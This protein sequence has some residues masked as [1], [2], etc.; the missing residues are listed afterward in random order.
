LSEEIAQHA[1]DYER[2]AEL[3]SRLD[4]LAAERDGLETE[5]LE[6]AAVLG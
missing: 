1:G 2:L 3:S 5:W 4:A 6:V